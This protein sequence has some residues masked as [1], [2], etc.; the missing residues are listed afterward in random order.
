MGSC[1]VAASGSG[2][3]GSAVSSPACCPDGLGNGYTSTPVIHSRP[4]LMQSFGIDN[5]NLSKF[6]KLHLR[7]IK[8]T[9]VCVWRECLGQKDKK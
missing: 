5:G 4:I 3:L 8:L 9:V 6:T 7:E 2:C 1:A